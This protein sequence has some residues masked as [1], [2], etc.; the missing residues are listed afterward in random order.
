MKVV[1]LGG[2]TVGS[3]IADLLCRNRHSVTVVDN[4]AATTRR[5]N[6]FY[7]QGIWYGG[8]QIEDVQRIVEETVL[9]GRVI[10][11]LL[12]PDECLNTKGRVPLPRDRPEQRGVKAR[13]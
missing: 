13:Q 1:I 2:G 5:L 3:S 9:S 12:I 4:D 6:V 11:H 8:V 10:E 7:P